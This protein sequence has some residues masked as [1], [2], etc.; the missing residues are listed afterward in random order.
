MTELTD[1]CRWRGTPFPPQ[2]LQSLKSR[3]SPPQLYYEGGPQA[4]TVE[5]LLLGASF[6]KSLSITLPST[7]LDK[8][9]LDGLQKLIFSLPNLHRLLLKQSADPVWRIN[10]RPPIPLFS[11]EPDSRLPATLRVLALAN[12]TL[13]SEQAD[14][15]ARCIQNLDL[16]H[17]DLSG[18]VGEVSGSLEALTGCVPGLNSFAIRVIE[19][20]D[21]SGLHAQIL[22]T[23][24]GFF[25]QIHVLECLSVNYLPKEVLYSAMRHH[26]RHLRQLRIQNTGPGEMYPGPTGDRMC[27]FSPEE[28]VQLS[29]ALPAVKR[30]G[31]DLGLKSEIVSAKHSHST[32]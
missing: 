21:N 19:L 26:G 15:W 10:G 28:I 32:D 29:V 12:L 8:L 25:Q 7:P 9:V 23:L 24:D 22:A 13:N 4:L 30:L 2:L 17:L 31:L 3:E 1:V 11:L 20:L 27:F 14:A 6:I 18:F 16:R 5:P